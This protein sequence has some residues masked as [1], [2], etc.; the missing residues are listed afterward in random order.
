MLRMP[1]TVCLN[2]GRH[3]HM[4]K[5]M[6][7]SCSNTGGLEKV[8]CRSEAARPPAC[9]FCC[10]WCCCAFSLM[11][12]TALFSRSMLVVVVVVVVV[13]A[14]VVVVVVVAAVMVVVV[15]VVVVVLDV[16]VVVLTAV[17]VVG[18]GSCGGGGG[19]WVHLLPHNNCSSTLVLVDIDRARSPPS[20]L[21]LVRPL[22]L[23]NNQTLQTLSLLPA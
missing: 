21:Q 12:T 6:N 17:V 1:A 5:R 18:G 23:H 11:V 13:V 9:R 2:D 4:Y 7:T 19:G 15:S 8:S 14:V 10:R 22:I 3:I 16:I 20:P